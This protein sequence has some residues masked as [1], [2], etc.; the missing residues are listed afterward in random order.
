MD[1]TKRCKCANCHQ[2]FHADARNAWH[3]RYCEEPACRAASKA[4]SQRRWLGRNLLNLERAFNPQRAWKLLRCIRVGEHEARRDV[5]L[6]RRVEVAPAPE[7]EP[8]H[9]CLQ[10]HE[11]PQVDA[12]LLKF[13]HCSPSAI[14]AELTHEEVFEN[15]LHVN[16]KRR[17]NI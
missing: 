5:P 6:E 9:S 16:V 7:L 11:C 17:L 3:Q 13:C 10:S 1:L 2:P 4:A 14:L 8:F 15:S 12:W